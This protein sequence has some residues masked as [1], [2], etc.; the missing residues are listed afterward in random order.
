MNLQQ[1]HNTLLYIHN[2]II[3]YFSETGPAP[4][5]PAASTHRAAVGCQRSWTLPDSQ[6][7]HHSRQ[8]RLASKCVYM[9]ICLS[10]VYMSTAVC[11]SAVC[12]RFG[13]MLVNNG[14][15]VS[16][17]LSVSLSVCLSFCP[18][19]CCLFLYLLSIGSFLEVR[20]HRPCQQS[21]Q[22]RVCPGSV[23]L[24]VCLC[25]LPV[26]L[27]VCMSVLSAIC[28]SVCCLSGPSWN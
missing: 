5:L 27:S 17:C 24:S 1:V 20:R 12:V 25:C 4:A 18:S 2:V 23:F 9:Y 10:I 22:G 8:Q 15:Q 14:S 3:R 16:V 6:E 26:C 11:F 28:L 21:S 19:V 13:T 7:R